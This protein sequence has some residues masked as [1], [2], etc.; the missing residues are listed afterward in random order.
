MSPKYKNYTDLDIQ[1]AVESSTSIAQVLK[2]LDL[3]VAGGNYNNIKK[4]IA[5]LG[6][7]TEH[8]KGK[9]W[10]PI[11]YEFKPF[12]GLRGK[13]AIKKRIAKERGWNC[14]KCL[15]TTW[16]DQPIS[17]ELEHINGNSNDNSK[18][19][20]LLL[21]PNCHA[22]TNTWRRRKTSLM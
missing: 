19:N 15:L 1:Q 14:E 11:G 12:E 13:E 6:L 22:Q 8:F 16:L 5:R 10:T 4:H 17:L 3:V 21:C 7:N 9:A 2:K 20:L 18:E